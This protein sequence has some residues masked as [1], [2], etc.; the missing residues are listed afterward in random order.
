MF[1]AIFVD[2]LIEFCWK[3]SGQT[4]AGPFWIAVTLVFATGIFG[5]L[6]QYIETLGSDS[7]DH[8][9]WTYDFRIGN[10]MYNR[11]S[12]NLFVG[13]TGTVRPSTAM[14]Y[15]IHQIEGF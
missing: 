7:T 10:Y 4:V 6:S 8:A 1:I 2:L 9:Y 15:R 14:F 3:N 11:V 12:H 5:N 13:V